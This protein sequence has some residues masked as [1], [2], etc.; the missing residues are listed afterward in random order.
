MTRRIDCKNKRRWLTGLLRRSAPRNDG[1]KKRKM[2]C[3]CGGFP[4]GRRDRKELVRGAKFEAS[5]GEAK[6]A[7]E[8]SDKEIQD[9]PRNEGAAIHKNFRR[10]SA[11][12]IVSTTERWKSEYFET[13][14]G[15]RKMSAEEFDS[16]HNQR[17]LEQY[18]RP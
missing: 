18:Q 15:A 6:R 16:L 8:L 2:M 10:R 4:Y 17:I 7:A 3:H 11:A 12:S 5:T 13:G 1:E 14:R 9:S